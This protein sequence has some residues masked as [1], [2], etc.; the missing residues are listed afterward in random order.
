MK[1]LLHRNEWEEVQSRMSK[2]SS[3]KSCECEIGAFLRENSRASV[4]GTQDALLRLNCIH[5]YGKG[6]KLRKKE[7]I[8]LMEANEAKERGI[9]LVAQLFFCAIFDF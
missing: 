7:K 8:K 6:R 2:A 9:S 5:M 1:P 4:V 3:K